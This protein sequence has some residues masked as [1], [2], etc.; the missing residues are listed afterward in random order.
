MITDPSGLRGLSLAGP[1]EKAL[2]VIAR[3]Q[4]GSPLAAS[5]ERVFSDVLK[6]RGRETQKAQVSVRE[7]PGSVPRAKPEP[8]VSADFAPSVRQEGQQQQETQRVDRES[9]RSDEATASSRGGR[10]RI[11]S[12]DVVLKFMDSIESELGIPPESILAAS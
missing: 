12:R 2:S 8:K 3:E 9:S 11:A 1:G 4:T 7:V 6:A 10:P 5:E